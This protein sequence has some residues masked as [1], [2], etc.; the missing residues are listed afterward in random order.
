MKYLIPI[1]FVL[2]VA[3]VVYAVTIDPQCIQACLKQGYSY[4]FCHRMCTY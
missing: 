4:D 3:S 2:L 1:L